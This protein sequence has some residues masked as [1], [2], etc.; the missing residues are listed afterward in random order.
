MS[1]IVIRDLLEKKLGIEPVVLKS[2]PKKDWP[3]MYSEVTEEQRKYLD[4]KVIQPAYN[5]FVELVYQGRK[6]KL[7]MDRVR[8]LA[9]G[10]IYSAQEA[11]DNKLID[12]IGY[13]ESAVST[14][15]SLASIS[16]AKVVECSRPFSL[17][18]LLSAKKDVMFKIDK[19]AIHQ[20]QTPEL[21]Y[22]WDMN[23]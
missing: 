21:L 15:E 12:S 23:N 14:A 22:I 16:N 13:F 4:E 19:E 20:W 3:S 9:D 8:Q 1:S 2:G 7:S 5:R 6:D 18:M 10:S 11:V 17:P